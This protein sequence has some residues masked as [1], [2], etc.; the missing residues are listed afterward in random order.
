MLPRIHFDMMNTI[1]KS[2]GFTPFQL[3]MGRSPRVIPPLILAKSSATVSDVDAW[4]VIWQLETDVLKAQDNLLCAKISQSTQANKHCTLKFPFHIGSHVCLS[5]LH[6]R[7]DY[8][9]KGEKCVAK[10]ML[11]FDGPYM[12]IDVNKDHSTVTLDLPNSPN[13]FPVFHTLEVLPYS[14]SDIS[15]FP[16]CRMEEPPPITTPDGNDKY[17]IDKILDARRHGC[18]YQYLVHWSSYG[19]EH[20]KWLPGSELQDCKVLDHWLASRVGS[21]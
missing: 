18:G 19:A 1:N 8:K 12:V 4:H 9:S 21:P 3:C 10:F 16:S 14:E 11:H 2:T 17:F 5:T 13:I 15:L 7:N 6:C 20:D